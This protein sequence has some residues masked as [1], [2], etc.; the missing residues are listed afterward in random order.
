MVIK[1]VMCV[2]T[3]CNL[4]FYNLVCVSVCVCMSI[5]ICICVCAL[6]PCACMCVCVSALYVSLFAI[7][8]CMVRSHSDGKKCNYYTMS[9]VKTM[10]L[11]LH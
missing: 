3:Y 11:Y 6:W 2:I 10:F 4:H 5:I 9:P 1:A 7:F 8:V